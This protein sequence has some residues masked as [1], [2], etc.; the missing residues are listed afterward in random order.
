MKILAVLDTMWDHTQSGRRAPRW[1]EI[2]PDNA[3]GRRLYK[4]VGSHH[5]RVT[6]AC[7][8]IARNASQHGVPDS[9]WLQENIR[10]YDPQLLM[11]CGRVAQAT[12]ERTRTA[13][14]RV[15][16][17][18]HPAARRWSHAAVK[19]AQQAV[20]ALDGEHRAL[21]FRDGGAVAQKFQL[22]VA[23]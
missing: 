2:N 16:L 4:I 9:E 19:A 3:S 1:F 8:Y 21:Y 15:L 7:Q 13:P 10:R 23:S 5:L 17:M 14:G 6:N 20:Q 22:E 12:W 18:P 11:V